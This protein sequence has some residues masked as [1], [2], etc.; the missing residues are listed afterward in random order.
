MSKIT[1]HVVVVLLTAPLMA[2]DL[3]TVTSSH[4][5]GTY[6][7]LA[8]NASLITTSDNEIIN[9]K[10]PAQMQMAILDQSAAIHNATV[11]GQPSTA[12]AAGLPDL[13][14]A[15][16]SFTQTATPTGTPSVAMA[17][18]A[19]PSYTPPPF[20]SLANSV[21]F[22]QHQI[23]SS[24]AGLPQTYY[25][26]S[27]VAT[28]NP[29]ID[30]GV[31]T[32]DTSLALMALIQSGNLSQ[33]QSIL[34]IYN[35]GGY[36]SSN[37][38]ANP[39]HNGGAFQQFNDNAYYYFDF[40]N[41][42]AVY[43][44][45]SA[46]GQYGSHTGPNAWLALAACQYIQAERSV[47]V[48]DTA[49][50]PYLNLVSRIGNA[51]ILLQD[52]QTQGGVRYGP[53]QTVNDPYN[54]IN[55]ENDLDAYSA[56]NSISQVMKQSTLTS[57]SSTASTYS[58]ASGKIINWLQS[59]S[60]YNPTTGQMQ[61]GMRDPQTGMLYVGVVY[62]GGKWELQT[63]P[64]FA[65]DSA[66]TWAISALGPKQIDAMWG[67][68]AALTM[69]ESVRKNFG[70]TETQ[71]GNP[72]TITDAGPTDPLDGLDYTNISPSNQALISPEWTAGG[73][74]ALEQL[75]TYYGGNLAASPNAFPSGGSDAVSRASDSSLRSLSTD[76][77]SMKTFLSQGQ[78]A[79]AIG[80]GLTGSRDGQTG[81]G[82]QVP[83][84]TSIA[85]MASIYGT[86]GEDPLAAGRPPT[87]SR[88][89]I[90]SRNPNLP[91]R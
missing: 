74:N 80:P 47:G 9:A 14:G 44:P 70:R 62:Q 89:P 69:W 82:T 79:Y 3:A 85:A 46:W 51:M 87:T 30:H 8:P 39:S 58:G 60:F 66:G 6:V 33:A 11:Q 57:F 4:D 61:K 78:D 40:A 72:S 52:S 10:T 53:D 37:L 86:L 67:N 15:V 18:P 2:Q 77:N 41:A 76:L 50:T 21:S 83:L 12:S 71:P 55:T 32:Y 45:D 7:P 73:I 38:E 36:G 25:N 19:A 54:T 29:V 63:Q 13:P 27:G 48:S 68:G 20:N 22:I 90:I 81:F 75:I 28:G 1:L 42:N 65:A 56:F 49:L 17:T 84:N 31:G 35:S 64:S 24:V 43:Q 59:G 16:L 88:G 91:V 23:T 26:P 5:P 34:N